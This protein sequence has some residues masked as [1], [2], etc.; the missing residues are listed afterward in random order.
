MRKLSTDISEV[1]QNKIIMY[2]P[3][4]NLDHT[5][6]LF[7]ALY[8]FQ[9]LTRGH[10]E[11][12]ALLAEETAVRTKKDAK[13][14]FFAGLLHD[15]GKIVL[16]PDLFSGCDISAEE[17][18]KIKS[19]AVKGFLALSEFHLFVALCAGLHHNLYQ[20]GYGVDLED[21]PSEISP[22]TA[23]KIL[24]ISGIIS[25]CDFVD[26]FTHRQTKIKDGSDKQASDLEGMLKDKYPED[27]LLIGV[28]L[29]ANKKLGL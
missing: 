21:F 26:A 24:E 13:A 1:V 14:A 25:I 23:K 19:Y 3:E 20:S 2:N 5:A 11:R 18:E 27:H 10:V 15:V 4:G 28:I 16:G 22:A 17:Y 29:K 8:N 12:V 6:R 9:P 7:L